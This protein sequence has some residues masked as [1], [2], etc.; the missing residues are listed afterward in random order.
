MNK[1]TFKKSLMAVAAGAALATVGMSAANANSLLFPYFATQGGASSY[2]ILRSNNALTPVAAG[3]T[4]NAGQSGQQVSG[5]NIHYV[6]NVFQGG[7]T[8]TGGAKTCQ[9]IDAYGWM[10]P[11][12]VSFQEISAPI[13]GMTDSSIPA[14]LPQL[15]AGV[16]QG[17]LVVSDVTVAHTPGV[18]TTGSVLGAPASGSTALTPTLEGQMIVADPTTGSL[19][20]YN[21]IVGNSAA[22][23]DFTNIA[24]TNFG[25][26]WYPQANAGVANFKT[27]YYALAVG[28]MS[29]N[30][31]GQTNWTSTTTGLVSSPYNNDEV[32][33]YSGTTP[34]ALG[35]AA[36]Y[37]LSSMMN[38]A[39]YAVV[40]KS[41]GQADLKFTPGGATG[42]VLTKIDSVQLGSG[43]NWTPG[44][45]VLFTQENN[46]NSTAN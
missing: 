1:I 11:N 6:W 34:V 5:G 30:I 28:N 14:L 19:F 43:V 44:G 8:S 7:L 42:V 3:T 38:A 22:E 26:S 37:P 46:L 4:T 33:P 35:C 39:Q 45:A 27:S 21:G 13:S 40:G 36:S 20:A 29:A 41:G 9:H 12:D 10:T 16:V 24:A 18:T 2:L 25:L 31:T 32:L 15:G 23:G 17:F